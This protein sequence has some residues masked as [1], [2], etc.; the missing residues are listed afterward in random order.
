MTN[1]TADIYV[2]KDYLWKNKH[3]CYID[4]PHVHNPG[5][6]FIGKLDPLYQYLASHTH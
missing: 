5:G 1:H 4:L 3:H 6:G 2:C